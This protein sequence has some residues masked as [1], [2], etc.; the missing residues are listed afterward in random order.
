MFPV[1]ALERLLT[2]EPCGS[3]LKV[4]VVSL[5]PYGTNIYSEFGRLDLNTEAL[6]LRKQGIIWPLVSIDNTRTPVAERRAFTEHRLRQV[7]SGTN[8]LV[9]APDCEP[10]SLLNWSMEDCSGLR[11]MLSG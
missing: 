5:V 7:A 10:L 1:G 2:Y 11:R 6:S 3:A 8:F 9:V 4:N